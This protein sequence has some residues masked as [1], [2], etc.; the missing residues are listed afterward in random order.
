MT[1]ADFCG[2]AAHGVLNEP[3]ETATPE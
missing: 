1:T 2:Y 3:R